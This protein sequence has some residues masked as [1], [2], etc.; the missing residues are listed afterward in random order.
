MSTGSCG[1]DNKQDQRSDE[2]NSFVA[3][4]SDAVN[5]RRSLAI[6]G[7]FIM[8]IFYT[9]YFAAPILMPITLSLLLNMLLTPGVRFLVRI[10]I[11]QVLAAGIVLLTALTILL[12]GVYL[13]SVPA[14][15]WLG[16][17][18]ASFYRVEQK[19]RTLKKP[20]EDIQKA[21]EKIED[22]AKIGN[23]TT[24]KVEIGRP[25][26]ADMLL[27]GTPQALASAGSIVVLV[28]FL[29]SSGDAFL[30]KL[31]IV[32]PTLTDKKRAVEIVRSIQD[33]ISF[34]LL[35]VTLVN[36]GLGIA[37][38]LAMAFL[39]VPNPLLWGAMVA[40]LNFAP[41]VGAAVN[42]L[43]LT[44]VGMVTFDS[45][46]QSLLVPGVM[47]VLTIFAGQLI[48]PAVL[49]RRLLLSPVAIFI[50]IMVW[51][52]LWGIAGALL[53]VPLLASCKII[54]ERIAP[55]RPIAEFLTP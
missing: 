41:Y 25:G 3:L 33:D 18:S 36:L 8:M 14:Q 4:F 42:L 50:A 51:G 2:L 21:T 16:K 11:P 27:S 53:A 45:L 35:T 40:L 17:A 22:A 32:V 54:C 6:S 55:L 24:Q 46:S 5:Q 26:V 10:R 9:L 52:W 47:A 44:V 37:V 1:E 38:A 28:F 30:R 49:G 31:V 19:L 7:I 23:D 20:I 15:D 34:Y 48:L 12:S 39:N 13:L 43:V 29:L